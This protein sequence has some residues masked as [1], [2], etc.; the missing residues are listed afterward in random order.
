MA[1]ITLP[2]GQGPAATASAGEAKGLPMAL[3]PAADPQ[4]AGAFE[5]VL[6]LRLGTPVEGIARPRGLGSAAAF[7]DAPIDAAAA[8]AAPVQIAPPHPGETGAIRSTSAPSSSPHRRPTPR[9][10]SRA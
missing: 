6:A 10:R 8:D 3:E 4:P 1:E 9:S 2:T 5:L 7:A